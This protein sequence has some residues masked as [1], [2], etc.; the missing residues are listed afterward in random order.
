MEKNIEKKVY[1]VRVVPFVLCERIEGTNRIRKIDNL[2]NEEIRNM[3]CDPRMLWETQENVYVA[4][5]PLTF[6]GGTGVKWS[7]YYVFSEL[8]KEEQEKYYDRSIVISMTRPDVVQVY[9]EQSKRFFGKRK[10]KERK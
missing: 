3:S 2:S 4:E 9:G 10:V 8:T 6:K 5:M 1:D 7:L